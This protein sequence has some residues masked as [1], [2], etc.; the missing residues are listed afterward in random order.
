MEKFG[1]FDLIGKFQG[2]NE[3]EKKPDLDGATATRP[4]ATTNEKYRKPDF[5]A[6]PQYLLNAKTRAYLA[7]HD[8][9]AAAVRPAEK[10]PSEKTK[11]P[12]SKQG[13]SQE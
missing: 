5:N 10:D 4:A 7:R 9:L 11:T 13:T 2:S 12:A 8:A 6:P 1:L 3:G